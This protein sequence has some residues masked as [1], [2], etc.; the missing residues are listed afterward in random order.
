[1]S[2]ENKSLIEEPSPLVELTEEAHKH[3]DAM[4]AEIDLAEKNLDGLEE[5]GLDVSRLREKIAWAKKARE[6]V[7]KTMT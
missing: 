5:L 2:P 7:L 6:V 3:L 4:K 1:M